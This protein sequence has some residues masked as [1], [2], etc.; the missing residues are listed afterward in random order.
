MKALR[1]A[2]QLLVGIL[3]A[4]PVGVFSRWPDFAPVPA[5]HG[6]FKLSLA[7]L[8]D[9][10]QP[11]HTLSAEEREALPPNMRAFEVC[12]RAR[13]SAL[14]EVVLDGEVVLRED[15]RPAGLHRDGRAYLY[16]AWPL[17]AGEYDLQLRLRDS[18]RT[19]GFDHEQSFRLRLEPGVSA[20]LSVGDGKAVLKGTS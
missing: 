12:E 13:A 20:L 14:V 7:H 18:P 4:I 11:C 19:E 3:F 1:L 9:R 15:V 8:T 6:E 10:M 16:R 5:A 2:G 17:R